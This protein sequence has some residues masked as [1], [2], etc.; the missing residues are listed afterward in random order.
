MVDVL[1]ECGVHCA[2]FGNHD[3]GKLKMFEFESL[4]CGSYE[5]C[6]S[7]ILETARS[8]HGPRYLWFRTDRNTCTTPPPPKK[9]EQNESL[10]FEIRELEILFTYRL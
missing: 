4:V 6:P 9:N 8:Q 5:V 10:N 3:F 2:V 1:N 7:L